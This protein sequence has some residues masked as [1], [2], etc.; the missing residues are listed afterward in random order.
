MTQPVRRSAGLRA[1]CAWMGTAQRA[2]A[3]VVIAAPGVCTDARLVLKRNG[4]A[5]R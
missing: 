5:E 1:V 2:W 3:T 4:E